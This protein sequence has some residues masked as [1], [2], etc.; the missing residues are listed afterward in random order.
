MKRVVL[1]ALLL[2][3][4]ATPSNIRQ[5]PPIDTFHT[6]K[7]P[8]QVIQCLA[9]NSEGV[10]V[11]RIIRAEH[12]TI[13]SFSQNAV[14]TIMFSVTPYGTI[15]VRRLHKIVPYHDVIARCV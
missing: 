14:A 11:P 12:E 13:V 3:G 9:R 1:I 10:G 2:A 6:D 8:E 7:D 5:K 15:N 4:C